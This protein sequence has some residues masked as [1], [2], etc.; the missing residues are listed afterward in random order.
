[1]TNRLSAGPQLFDGAE[2]T[3]ATGPSALAMEIFNG[4]EAERLTLL[5]DLILQSDPRGTVWTRI[6]SSRSQPRSPGR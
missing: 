4:P 5:P 3:D 2:F 6:S 1:M